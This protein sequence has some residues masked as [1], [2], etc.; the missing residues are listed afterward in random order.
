MKN[1]Y[2]KKI[3]NQNP[4]QIAVIFLAYSRLMMYFKI[5]DNFR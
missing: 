5:A 3:K 4:L 1:N 2:T